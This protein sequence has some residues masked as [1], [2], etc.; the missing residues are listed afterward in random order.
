M[1]LASSGC[2]QQDNLD[3]KVCAYLLAQV[4]TSN[5]GFYREQNTD[6]NN[7]MSSPVM[8]ISFL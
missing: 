4:T 8:H 2:L 5:E 3:K 1:E 7:T 6:I